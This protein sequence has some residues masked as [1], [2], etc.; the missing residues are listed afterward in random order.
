MEKNLDIV[1][2]KE[3]G[4]FEAGRPY[5]IVGPCSAESEEQVMETANGLAKA[6]VTVFRAGLWKP[7]THPGCFEGVGEKGLPWLQRVQ[8]E[9]GM[10]VCTEV[11][12]AAHVR[13]AVAHGVDMVWIGAR[14]TA[15]PFLVQEIADELAGTDIPVLVKNPVNRDLELWTGAIERLQ[16]RGIC[17]I[18]VV[19]RGFSTFE[20]LRYRNSPEWHVAVTLRSRHPGIPFF[21]DPSHMGGSRDLVQ[22][23]SQKAMDLGLDGLMVESHCKPSEALSDAAQQLTPSEFGAMVSGL[24]IRDDDSEEAGYR[25]A[26]DELRASIDAIDDEL[27][28]NLAS[29]MEVSRRIGSIKKESNI[30]I[31]QTTRWEALMDKVL[32]RASGLGLDPAFVTSVFENIHQASIMEQNKTIDNNDSRN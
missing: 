11:A 24:T 7:R 18:G 1:P 3:W 19:H 13:A 29:R 17:K 27:L 31:I 14:T 22:E 4:I 26:I 21:C 20:T 23:I 9:L 25:S 28:E 30:A 6:G 8:A 2:V 32:Q 10:K 15:N 12:G 16:R 5:L